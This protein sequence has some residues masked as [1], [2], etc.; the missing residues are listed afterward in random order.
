MTRPLRPARRP[1]LLTLLALGGLLGTGA[2]AC[3][4]SGAGRLVEGTVLDVHDGDSFV[5]R[6]GDGRRLRVRVA[7]IDAPEHHQPWAE[8]SRRQ[9]GELL[10]GHRVQVEPLKTDVYERTVARVRVP[11]E[12]GEPADVALVLL[13][14]GLAWHF[15]RYRSDQSAAEYLRYARAERAARGKRVGLWQ[16]PTPEPPWAFRSRM[17]RHEAAPERLSPPSPEG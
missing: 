13:E 3:A 9:L 16:D 11:T 15:V 6:T 1:A 14:S 8:S 2:P 4:R 12:D 7:G 10:R 17:R 5:L